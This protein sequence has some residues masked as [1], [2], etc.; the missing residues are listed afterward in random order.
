MV[1]PDSP[2]FTY[3]IAAEVSSVGDIPEGMSD[4]N[5][6]SAMYA[7]V[8]NSTWRDFG[9][10]DDGG[11]NISLNTDTWTEGDDPFPISIDTVI[12][13]RFKIAVPSGQSEDTYFSGSISS[14]GVYILGV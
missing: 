6:P 13:V 4:F 14:Y 1:K 10:F 3:A 2:D 5:L 12:Y 7:S 9:S 8:D 11:S